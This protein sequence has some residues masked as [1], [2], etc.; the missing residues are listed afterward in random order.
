MT[1]CPVCKK[2]IWWNHL[3]Y[4]NIKVHNHCILE[5]GKLFTESGWGDEDEKNV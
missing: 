3:E 4:Y 1:K 5:F 2:R